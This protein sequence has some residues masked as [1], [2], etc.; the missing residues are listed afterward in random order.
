M[1]NKDWNQ[2]EW[3]SLVHGFRDELKA[4]IEKLNEEVK[5]AR[6]ESDLRII[7]YGLLMLIGYIGWKVHKIVEKLDAFG[8]FFLQSLEY[9][10]GYF[11]TPSRLRRVK[12]N[13]YSG[14]CDSSFERILNV[15]PFPSNP[16]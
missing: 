12:S 1:S 10:T 15:C 3:W 8:R 9:E 14:V 6:S 16:P 4:D 7:L 5:Q 2:A 13:P 11:R